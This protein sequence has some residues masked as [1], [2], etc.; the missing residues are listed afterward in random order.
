MTG[1]D[2]ILAGVDGSTSALRA[3]A[4]AARTAAR[5]HAPLVLLTVMPVPGPYGSGVGLPATFFDGMEAE[6]RRRLAEATDTAKRAAGELP[7]LTVEQEFY[8]GSPVPILRDRAA[9]AGMLV[10]GTRGLGELTGTFVGS[11]AVALVSHSPCPVAVVRGPTPE[12]EPPTDGP[13]AVGVDGSPLS[14]AA[15]AV[16]FEEASLRG[17]RLVAVHAW[18]D[19]ARPGVFGFPAAEL[20]WE[21][22]E[23]AE[24]VVLAERLA[25]WR[26]RYPDVEVQR[27]VTR[28]RPARSLLHAAARSQLLVVGSRGRGG[29]SGM[30]LGS[31]SNALIY[32]APC[33]LLIVRAQS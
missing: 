21:E 13:V 26:E 25:G 6:G 32:S 28:D 19:T 5:R 33:P 20:P 24:Q 11:V 12:A 14:D 27:V 7:G 15:V 23:T 8:V 1:N 2:P 4:W 9:S 10:L 3:T 29:F 17:V 30:L 16:A 22:I 18:S 31:T